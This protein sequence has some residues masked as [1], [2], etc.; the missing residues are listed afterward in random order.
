M[1]CTLNTLW[2]SQSYDSMSGTQ[3]FIASH[4]HKNHIQKSD[5]FLSQK[6]NNHISET[7]IFLL[8]SF[9][10]KFGIP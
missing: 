2:T 4:K 8:S 7:N 1:C 10:S 9:S 6:K 5:M 3:T